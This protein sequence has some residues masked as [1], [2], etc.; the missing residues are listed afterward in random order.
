MR[1]KQFM[2]AIVRLV[3]RPTIQ[4]RWSLSQDQMEELQCIYH[5][6]IEPKKV[7]LP[8]IDVLRVRMYLHPD[9]ILI[10]LSTWLW[11]VNVD[12]GP[13]IQF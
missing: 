9:H 12:F 2:S 10:L 5:N 11:L 7:N 3:I 1:N 13:I 4:S 8:E 6:N